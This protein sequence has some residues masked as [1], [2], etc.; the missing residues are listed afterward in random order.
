MSEIGLSHAYIQLASFLRVVSATM[1]AYRYPT[2]V[3][4]GLQFIPVVVFV[5]VDLLMFLRRL[6][7]VVGETRSVPT[8][9][10]CLGGNHN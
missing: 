2:V 7:A 9:H 6:A 1:R 4:G 8:M 5:I 10:P 3:Q